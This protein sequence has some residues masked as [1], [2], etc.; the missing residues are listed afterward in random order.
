[1]DDLVEFAVRTVQDAARIAA[2]RF[3]EGQQVQRKAD[4]TQVTAADVEVEQ[5]VR[6][7]L[8]AAFPDD[9]VYGE[10][11]GLR[12]GTSGRRWLIDPIDG[13]SA[14]VRR[15]P[16]FSMNLAMVD[17]G[18]PLVGV[19]AHPMSGVVAFA[20]RGTGSWRKINDGLPERLTVSAYPHLRGAKVAIH[21]VATWSSELLLALHRETYLYEWLSTTAVVS[22][23]LDASVVAGMPMSVE[24]LGPLP[25]LVEEAGGR[26]TDL[27]GA[28][29]LSGDGTI[30]ATNGLVHEAVLELVRGLP[31]GRDYRSLRR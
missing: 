7:R 17:N 27:T 9:A 5:F 2:R 19:V 11:R 13:T 1:V 22:G 26:I 12:E 20:G 29:L 6:A 24:D 31:T 18:V 4:R 23:E 21:N 10:E 14:F 8:A 3:S 28:P 30:L 25:L 16:T 15:I